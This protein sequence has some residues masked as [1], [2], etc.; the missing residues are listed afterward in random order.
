MDTITSYDDLLSPTNRDDEEESLETLET[1]E[2]NDYQSSLSPSITIEDAPT[3][4][5]QPV[6][7]RKASKGNDEGLGLEIAGLDN[8]GNVQ[9]MLRLERIEKLETRRKF[10]DLTSGTKRGL[11]MEEKALQAIN[12]NSLLDENEDDQSWDLKSDD[13]R[14]F[15]NWNMILTDAD[16]NDYSFAFVILGTSADDVASMPHVLSPPL[17]E[18]LHH[19]LPYS[20]SEQNFFMKYSLIRDGASFFTLLQNV[21]GS[22]H[23][24][25]AIET[26]YGEVFGSFSSSQW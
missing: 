4:P 23:T 3:V 7:I 18:S 11:S 17:M 1:I 5:P 2:S 25:I 24:V 6:L 19:F 21:R 16:E 8:S 12:M 14:P 26:T 22:Q 15:D 20:V 10:N 13:G 9:A